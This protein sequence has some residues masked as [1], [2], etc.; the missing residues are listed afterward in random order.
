V[1][2]GTRTRTFAGHVGEVNQT[3]GERE[4]AVIPRTIPSLLSSAIR[5]YWASGTA[6]LAIG[7][8]VSIE[9]RACSVNVRGARGN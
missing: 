5:G 1:R 9:G 8:L 2:S 3:F 7:A 4:V 6:H